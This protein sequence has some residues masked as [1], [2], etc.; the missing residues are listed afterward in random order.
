MPTGYSL[1]NTP[2]MKRVIFT[3]FALC[4]MV[5]AA[6]LLYKASIS[7]VSEVLQPLP[8]LQAS[9]TAYA[10]GLPAQLI[11]P[12]I[13]LDANI[14]TLGL[15]S[16]SSGELAVPKN[17]IDVGWYKDGPRP[18]APG[19]AVIDGH[20]NGKHVPEAVFFKLNTLIEGD[21]VVVIDEYS[22]QLEF[23]VTA[24]KTFA[25]NQPTEEVF[26]SDTQESRL[27]L[28]TCAGDWLSTE[29][30]YDKRTVVFTK[31]VSR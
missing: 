26:F 12:K 23:V 4:I 9:S 29:H 11:I 31:L 6:F 18:G 27:N 21:S 20:F 13:K 17:F 28:I 7:P 10:P 14:E 22:H 25:Y 24:V 3:S 5:S 2:L 15:T 19:S 8:I 16:S 1:C 30:L